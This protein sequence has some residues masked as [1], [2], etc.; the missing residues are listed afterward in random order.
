MNNKLLI[1]LLSLLLLAS[2]G[3][4]GRHFRIDGRFRHLNQGEFYVYSPD[5]TI[6]GLDTIKI[7]DGKFTYE[8]PCTRKGTLVLLFPNFSEQPVFTEPGK[9]VKVK[10]DA[11]HLKEMTIRGTDTC[12][13]SLKLIGRKHKVQRRDVIR[14]RHIAIIWEYGRQTL[15]LLR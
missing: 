9:T 12:Y 6:E 3:T 8:T 2:C 5:G 4:D 15:C 10:A 1:P 11:S 7:Q 14:Y 13:T